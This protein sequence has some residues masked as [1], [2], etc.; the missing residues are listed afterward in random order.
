MDQ[1]A[2]TLPIP[3]LRLIRQLSRNIYSSFKVGLKEIVLNSFDAGA[4]KVDIEADPFKRTIIITDNGIGMTEDDLYD[5]FLRAGSTTKKSGTGELGRPI[6]GYKGVGVF[7]VFFFAQ[8]LIVESETE[9]GHAT[10]CTVDLKRLTDANPDTPINDREVLTWEDLQP[11]MRARTVIRIESI[12]PQSFESMWIESVDPDKQPLFVYLSQV[13][14]VQYSEHDKG[15]RMSTVL[16]DQ[17]QRLT[18]WS[19]RVTLNGFPIMRESPHSYFERHKLLEHMYLREFAGELSQNINVRGV[20]FGTISKIKDQRFTG[21]LLRNNGVSIG[22]RRDNPFDIH[23]RPHMLQWVSGEVLI[24][25]DLNSIIT[26]D[27]E[28]LVEDSEVFF[29]LKALIEKH[30]SPFMTMLQDEGE[31]AKADKRRVKEERDSKVFARAINKYNESKE[32]PAKVELVRDE[33]EAPLVLIDE[34]EKKISINTNSVVAKTFDHWE[35]KELF[36]SFIAILQSRFSSDGF[37]KCRE[38]LVQAQS[39]LEE[40]I[41]RR[42]DLK[43]DQLDYGF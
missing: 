38:I 14:P 27:R 24:E 21:L 12:Q 17:N 33:S 31:R 30:L 15:V 22:P 29:E 16:Q 11:Q 9:T 41:N 23:S 18:E 36:Y 19:F 42:E 13:L 25:G 26:T 1:K 8:K 40:Y 35:E 37:E 2:L 5:Y 34:A 39:D 10:R 28:R 4:R 43:S 3:A 7:S 32:F 20:F 6:L